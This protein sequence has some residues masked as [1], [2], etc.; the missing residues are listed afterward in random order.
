MYTPQDIMILIEEDSA[1]VYN[2]L[3][4]TYFSEYWDWSA[5]PTDDEFIEQLE[6]YEGD[7]YG[8]HWWYGRVCQM[9]EISERIDRLR[10]HLG[11]E[12][13]TEYAKQN[14]EYAKTYSDAINLSIEFITWKA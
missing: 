9:Q 5:P 11:F 12:L 2:E 8:V 13:Q 4:D 7:L 3:R 10:S 6:K 1:D 14:P